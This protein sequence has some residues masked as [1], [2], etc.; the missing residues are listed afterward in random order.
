M[1]V[2]LSKASR[3]LANHLYHT[4]PRTVPIFLYPILLKKVTSTHISLA[5]RRALG[6][7]ISAIPALPECQTSIS[8][9]T[10]Q[11]D[12]PALTRAMALPITCSGC[13]ALNQTVNPG[14]AGFYS[15][16][17]KSVKAFIAQNDLSKCRNHTPEDGV[18]KSAIETA[19]H[20]LLRE[21]GL[22]TMCNAPG[23]PLRS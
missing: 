4:S 2:S 5:H 12:T 19:D 13:G 22:D 7:T 14:E 10:L 21:L 6:T 11:N 18:L 15:I 17:R 3:K 16:T 9:A 1:K 23:K 8:S 20:G